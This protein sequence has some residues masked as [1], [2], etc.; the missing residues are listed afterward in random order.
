MFTCTTALCVSAG[1][2]LLDESNRTSCPEP[3]PFLRD[4]RRTHAGQ[5]PFLG[6]VSVD[7]PVE[8]RRVQ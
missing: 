1:G 5:R 7:R 4:H 6:A 3:S 2:I 8:P